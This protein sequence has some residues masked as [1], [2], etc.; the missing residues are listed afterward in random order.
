MT[1]RGTVIAS[2]AKQ[3]RRV[4]PCSPCLRGWFSIEQREVDHVGQVAITGV[5]LMQPVGAIP[6]PRHLR[7][8]LRILS[9]GVEF[10]NPLQCSHLPPH[11]LHCDPVSPPPR[12]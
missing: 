4:S 1:A 8:D 12:L 10:C 3:S 11:V 5:T 7:R 9:P 2:E 6:F